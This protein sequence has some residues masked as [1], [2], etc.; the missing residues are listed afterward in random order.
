MTL[1]HLA[2]GRYYELTPVAAYIWGVLTAT[3]SMAVS[4]LCDRLIERYDVERPTCEKEVVR[5]M[6]EMQA[7]GLVTADADS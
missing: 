3:D 5:L 7:E 1:L 4:A 2:S 6:T